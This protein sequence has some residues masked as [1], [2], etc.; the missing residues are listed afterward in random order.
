MLTLINKKQTNKWETVAKGGFILAAVL[1]FFVCFNFVQAQSL[2]TGLAYAEQ[3]G[4]PTTDIR[5]IIANVIRVALGLMGLM[6]VVIILYGGWLWMSAG[7]N[8]EQIAKAK[9]TLINGAIG[10]IIILSAY[11]IVLFV[12]RLLGLDGYGVGTGENQ[13]AYEQQGIM[14]VAGSGA[15]GKVILDHYPTP[16]QIDVPRNTKI[17]I[18]FAK[19]VKIESIVGENDFLKTGAISLSVKSPSSTAPSGFESFPYQESVKVYSFPTE[20]TLPSGEVINEIFTIVLE[21]ATLLGDSQEKISYSVKINN[22][23]QGADGKSIFSNTRFSFYEW[24]FVCSTVE[25]TTPPRVVSVYPF[26]GMKETKDTAIE[27]NFNEPIFPNAQASFSVSSNGTYYQDK[28]NR[29]PIV[30]IKSGNSTVP[31]GS[32]KITNQYRTLEFSSSL[33]CG[34]D[35]CGLP[36]YCLPVCDKQG[37]NCTEDN[38]QVLFKTAPGSSKEN[39]N[40]FVADLTLG[41]GVMDM[42]GNALDGNADDVYQRNTSAP[43]TAGFFGPDNYGW[44]F[45]LEDKVDLTTPYIT[46]LSIG[47]ETQTVAAREDMF[48]VWSK[49]MKKSTLYSIEIEEFPS[50]EKRCTD[51]ISSGVI[52]SRVLCS[53]ETLGK[54]P[55]STEIIQ[56]GKNSYTI[57]QILHTP[58]LDGY[59]QYYL[60]E[61]NSAVKDIKENCFYPGSGPVS[62]GRGVNCINQNCCTGPYCCNGDSFANPFGTT[63]ADNCAASLRGE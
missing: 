29:D 39:V 57:T 13:Y 23:V 24:F 46:A 48:I 3:T 33:Q 55:S 38:Y 22:I 40:P 32:F 52:K 28:V 58:F 49:M 44:N 20:T 50:P 60:P 41:S 8:E 47:P 61:V 10:L 2:D 16:G 36:K 1:C 26:E 18:T 54:S 63:Y 31:L 25:D 37:V 51:L 34:K 53:L 9:K 17:A 6:A 45:I 27:I 42:A 30:F 11:S 12:M 21:P 4:L 62:K 7:G 56:E 59:N 19:P 43:F 35:P 5:L 14:N 15:W